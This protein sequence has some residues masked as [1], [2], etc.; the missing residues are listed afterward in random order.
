MAQ[1]SCWAM[2]AP[3]TGEERGEK[4]QGKDVG[5]GWRFISTPDVET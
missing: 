1:Y 5:G 4:F 3:F 2:L